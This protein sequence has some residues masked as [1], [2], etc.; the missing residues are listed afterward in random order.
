MTTLTPQRPRDTST[1]LATRL[2]H[3]RPPA[4]TVRQ[5]V[6][7]LFGGFYAAMAVVN[8]TVTLPHAPRV[9]ADLADMSWPGFD[10]AVRQLVIPVATPLTATVIVA[11]AGLAVLLL[12]RGRAVRAGLLAALAWQLGLAPFL[13]W[14]ELAN[15]ALSAV[16]LWLLAR[17]YGRSVIDV[18]IRR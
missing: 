7:L 16:V 3:P 17:D 6:R 2:W 5:S 13:S 15:V 12:S 9:Y 11:E 4:G 1:S 18:V 14:Y 10:A 8:A